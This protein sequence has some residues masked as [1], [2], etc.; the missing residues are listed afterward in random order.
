MEALALLEALALV[1]LVPLLELP[2]VLQMEPGKAQP[3][4]ISSA[5]QFHLR[6]RVPRLSA[7]ESELPIAG[8]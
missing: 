3:A 2:V 8:D 7:F 5:E 6:L 4:A 1:E